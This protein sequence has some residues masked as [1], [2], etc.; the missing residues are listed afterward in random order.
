MVYLTV[1]LLKIRLFLKVDCSLLQDTL[2][3][4]QAQL[5]HRSHARLISCPNW[6]VF[7]YC[8]PLFNLYFQF[9]NNIRDEIYFQV[10]SFLVL[11]IGYMVKLGWTKFTQISLT[12][13]FFYFKFF[14]LQ[15]SSASNFLNFKFLQLQ[16]SLTSNF[17]NF[18]VVQLQIC[19]TSNFFNFKFVQLQICLTSNLFNFKYFQLQISELSADST[20]LR[21]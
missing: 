6:L 2:L 13:N 4:S 11:D 20:P 3:Y 9:Q 1:F 16:I 7:F 21:S 12:S 10:C 17:F 14:Q 19:L 18:N 8:D 5:K 15:I